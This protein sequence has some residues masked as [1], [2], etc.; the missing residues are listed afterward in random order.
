M[1]ILLIS[2]LFL[3]V[4]CE[5]EKVPT[6]VVTGCQ[7]P[8]VVSF[9][10]DVQPIIADRCI[11]CH[12]QTTM[13]PLDNYTHVS[14]FAASAQLKGCLNG[15][16]NYTQMPP[17]PNQLDTCSENVIYKWIDAGYPNN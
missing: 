8:E 11:T 9:Q 6:I 1:K 4:A 14:A 16:S 12:D 17:Y 3:F 10:N 13:Y 2:I 7:L 15:N 5:K